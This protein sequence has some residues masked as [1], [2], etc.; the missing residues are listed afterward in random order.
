MKLLI[1]GAYPYRNNG[2]SEFIGQYVA[3]L[4]SRGHEVHTERFYFWKEKLRNGRWITLRKR[5][6]E[7]FDAVI[8]QHTATA[9]GPLLPLFLRAARKRG[10]P[11]AVVSHEMPSVYAK[12]L[13]R[14]MRPLYFAWERA[15][16]AGATVPVVQSELHAHEMRDIGFRHPLTVIPVPVYASTQPTPPLDGPRDSWGCFGMI[17]PKKGVDLLLKAYQCRP[18]GHF[19]PLVLLGGAAPGNEDYLESLKASVGEAYQPLI[20]FKGY[21][22]DAALP[23]ELSR[24][25]LV[26][27][28]YRWVSQSAVLTEALRHHVPYLASDIPFFA[29]F[30][31]RHGC[32]NLFR[33]ESVEDLLLALDAAREQPAVRTPETIVAFEAVIEELSL[34]RCADMLLASIESVRVPR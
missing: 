19:P 12:H 21:V 32:G 27:L 10:V 8:V 23:G 3:E 22:E 25:G 2:V 33:S 17:S 9:S 28:P 1:I 16:L 11:V 13:P 7:G 24:L 15:V 34:R 31:N 6:Q 26:I 5:L 30:R 29:E 4:T 18:P 14:I 20:T